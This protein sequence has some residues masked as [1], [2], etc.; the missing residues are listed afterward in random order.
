MKG[1][2]DAQKMYSFMPK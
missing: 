1:T 2:E